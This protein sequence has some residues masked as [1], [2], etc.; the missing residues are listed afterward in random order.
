MILTQLIGAVG[1][2]TLGLSYFKKEKKQI[3]FMQIIAY[4]FFALHYYLLSGITGT[5][6]N[7]I[8]LCALITI[9]FCDK[10]KLKSKK[11]ISLFF[12]ILLIIINIMTF[13]NFYSIFPLIASVIAVAS[14]IE[15]NENIIRIIGI[16]AALP[17]QIPIYYFNGKRIT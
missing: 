12:I 16:I 17:I 4:I 10:Y 14:F 2:T 9:Y 11:L 8:G 5:I 3:L 7:I 15:N 13:Q 6:C 1:Y